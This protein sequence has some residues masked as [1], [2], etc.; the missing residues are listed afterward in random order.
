V[1]YHQAPDP[2]DWQI[3]AGNMAAEL[4][5]LRRLRNVTMEGAT[6]T[7]TGTGIHISPDSTGQSFIFAELT[8]FGLDPTGL[9][10][11]SW[12]QMDPVGDGSWVQTPSGLSGGQG[13]GSAYE[14]NNYRV[15]PGQ[16][17]KLYPGQGTEYLFWAQDIWFYALLLAVNQAAR[18][19]TWQRVQPS[20]FGLWITAT[21][22]IAGIPQSGVNNAFEL[23]GQLV[24]TGPKS[25]VVM[26]PDDYGNFLFS[27]PPPPFSGASVLM[28]SF[29]VTQGG[30]YQLA[31]QW[32]PP[33]YDSDNY[34]AGNGQS[35]F[36]LPFGGFFLVTVNVGWNFNYPPNGYRRIRL[37]QIAGSNGSLKAS[38]DNDILFGVWNNGAIYTPYGLGPGTI[39]SQG[40]SWQIAGAAGDGIQVALLNGDVYSPAGYNGA[41]GRIS[42]AA[43]GRV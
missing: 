43:L 29:N 17:V 23:N 32:Y 41:G 27:A 33:D 34:A 22:N 11:Y 21:D 9:T 10:Y 3:D 5:E 40:L 19:Y 25:V 2:G 7:H 14:A 31:T 35:A 30:G 12:V 1:L 20:G 37:Q 39:G 42:I 36:I 6:V 24:K 4:A 13:N 26:Y 38:Q 15:T 16:I 28:Y 8:G 18:T